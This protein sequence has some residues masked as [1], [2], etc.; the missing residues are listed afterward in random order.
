MLHFMSDL[1]KLKSVTRHAW[2]TTGRQESVPEHTWRTAMMM[3]ALEEQIPE[4]DTARVIEMILV[5]DLGETFKGDKPAFD[6]PA[7]HEDHERDDVQKILEPL[8]EKTRTKL[9]ALWDEFEA[10]ETLEA[11]IANALEKIEAVIQHNEVSTDTWIPVEYE[12]QFK[13]G[14]EWRDVHPV[15]TEI[16][17]VVDAW[18]QKKIGEEKNGQD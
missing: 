2:L 12:Y 3:L 15:I 9:L 11:Q 18:T 14:K 7:N 16:H 1:E 6:K 17:K 5:H 13:H 4:V 8:G 10:S